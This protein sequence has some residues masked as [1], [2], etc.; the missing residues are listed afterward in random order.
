MSKAMR[1]SREI[2][3]VGR[4]VGRPLFR[5]RFTRAGAPP[6]EF[7][8]APDAL[9]PRLHAIRYSA[10][11]MEES[12]PTSAE[13]AHALLREGS[14]TW[15][16]VQGLAD[17][18]MIRS[19]GELFALHP[20]AVADT[21]NVGQRPKIDSYERRLFAAVRMV[22]LG[23]GGTIHWEQ[24][25]IFI[26]PGF[27]L[28][29]QERYEDCLNPIRERLRMGKRTLLS[30]GSDY[31]G[32]MLID[33]IVD[34]Y[35]PILEHY[36]ERLE[37]LEARVIENPSRGVLADVYRVKRE[38]MTFRR[39]IWPLRDAL[40][41]IVRQPHDLIG[42]TVL[43]YIRDA[44][45]HVMQVVDVNETYRELASSF[46]DVY[47]SSV[48]NRTNEVMR[49]L[50]IFA[51]IFI[52]LTFFAGIYGM[53]FDTDHPLNMPELGWRYGYLAFWGATAL[54]AAALV[55]LFWRLGWIGRERDRGDD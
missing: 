6:G 13:E 36:G 39:A 20:L 47:L 29:F 34:G 43:P 3:R 25:S 2:A 16:D 18:R 11:E 10:T 17:A 38:L 28:S 26:G 35:F 32:F 4:H 45:D 12:D 5:R 49:V 40:S 33:A 55:A 1:L 24:V 53:N 21:V 15:I 22:T 50:T 14:I 51:T 52:P 37:S 48:A 8:P 54:I 42:D 9:P 19:F 7:H 27:V 41:Q 30:S 46:V 23:E 44:T 31:L